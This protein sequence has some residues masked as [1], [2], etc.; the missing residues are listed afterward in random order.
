MSHSHTVSR[1]FRVKRV[2]RA[3]A[4]LKG[5]AV[6]YPGRDM[7]GCASDDSRIFGVE[8]IAVSLDQ[9]GEPFFTIP[10]EDVELLTDEEKNHG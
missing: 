5:G 7:Y 9:S 1:R 8:H 4:L 2:D 10:R 3:S 6:V